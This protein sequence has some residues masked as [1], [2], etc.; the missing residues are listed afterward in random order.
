MTR[1]LRII[2]RGAVQGVGFRPYV[3][4]LASEL[5]LGGWVLNSPEGVFIEVEGPTRGLQDLLLRLSREAPPRSSIHSLESLE[6]D[7]VGEKAFQ[8]RPSESTG[9]REALVMADIGT[10]PDC[11]AEIRDPAARRYRYPFTNCTNCGPRYSIILALPYDRPNTTMRA[12]AMCPACRSEYEDPADRRFHAQ[13]IACPK[14]GPQLALWEPDGRTAGRHAE[15]LAGA[16]RAIREGAIVALKG[17]G[18]FQLIADALNTN[19]VERLRLRKHREEKPF[20]LM[21]PSTDAAGMLCEVSPLEERLLTSPESPIVLLR[22][23]ASDGGLSPAVAPRN[24]FLGL[25]LPYTPLHHLLLGDLG[26]PVIATSGNISDEPLCIDE[27]EARERLSGIADLFLVH[28]RPIHRHVDDSIVRVIL[29]RECVL[30]RARGY[31]PLPIR[32]TAPLPDMLALGGQLKNTVAIS[33]GRNVF[34]SQHLGDLETE[35][36]VRAF[37]HEAAALQSLFA[38]HPGRVVSDLHPDYLSTRD[39]HESGIPVTG[40]QHHW[41]HIASCVAENGLIGPLL[42]VSWDGTGYG[43]DGTVWGGEFLTPWEGTFERRAHLRTF[44]LPGGDAAVREPRRSAAG[45]LFE[46]LGPAFIEQGDLP[47]VQGFTGGERELLVQILSRRV[48]APVSSSAGRLFDAVA[49]LLGLRQRCSFEGQAAMELEYLA[50]SGREP[51]EYPFPLR[52]G[53]PVTIDW[54]PMIRGIIADVRGGKD[55]GVIASR[56]H[57]TLA[58][59]IVSVARSLGIAQV[60]L[61]GGCFQN[62]IL[63]EETIGRLREAGF[64]PYWHQRVPPNDGGI[65]L[66]QL[67]AAARMEEK[68]NRR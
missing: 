43:T 28:D 18:G 23:R 57:N 44:S 60:V 3:Y 62:R 63:T 58:Q 25:M 48:N 6:I 36:S 32:C 49:S 54:E 59:G 35:A 45:I 53:A 47:T 68:K 7:P 55:R 67:V 50:D 34:L 2:I 20:A 51:G 33:R 24:P 13:P 9:E 4:R 52:E 41:A 14:C 29:D 16:V 8:I 26:T 61:S 15:A 40:I 10:C 30:R 39:A 21:V 12:F 5:H 31:A 56:F 22:R 27:E 19:A 46:C 1:R 38:I 37:R 65:A 17:L 42:G 66:G 11:L 64:R